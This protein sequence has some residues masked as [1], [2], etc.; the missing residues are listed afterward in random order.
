MERRKTLEPSLVGEC[1]WCWAIRNGGGNRWG[2]QFRKGYHLAAN[3][4][5]DV[6]IT[7]DEVSGTYDMLGMSSFQAGMLP[8]EDL[9]E[10]WESIKVRGF[11]KAGMLY[12]RRDG[13]FGNNI[14]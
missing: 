1:A 4:R 9:K 7:I 10:G 14:R 2:Y 3:A 5:C 8:E 11:W 6:E 13:R 12:T